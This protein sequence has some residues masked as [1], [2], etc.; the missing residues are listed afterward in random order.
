MKAALA[1]FGGAG[2]LKNMSFGGTRLS[3]KEQVSFAKRLAFLINAG[4]TL[5][6]G[7]TILREQGR[8]RTQK[9]VL[10]SVLGDI[11]AG[12]S[13]SRSFSK[14]PKTF[15]E[16]TISIVKVGE[17]SGTLAMSLTYLAE[18][19]RKKQILRRKVVSAFVYPALITVATLGIT[20]FLMLYLFPKIMPVF[21]SL[22]TELPLTTR[23][24]MATSVFFQQWGML[25]LFGTIAL[26]VVLLVTIKKSSWIHERVDRAILRLPVIGAIVQYY[27]VANSTRT[28]GLL[29]KSGV[30]LGEAIVITA[31]TTKNFVYKRHYEALAG[32]V[33]RGERM[34]A[35]LNRHRSVFPDVT[36]HMIAVGERSGTLSETLVY[37]SEL[38][39][40]EVDEF[41]KNLSTLIEPALMIV[42][43]VVVGFIAISIITPIYGI[44]QNLHG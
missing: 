9:K 19:L 18:E 37:L 30:R 33:N 25:A 6:E 16:F 14:F 11:T 23:M 26:I 20:A 28:L 13:L 1:R 38:Y 31:D 21:T 10:D 43:G 3:L 29:L 40:H 22:H 36:A 41:T 39:E 27:N 5:V 15:G 34:S 42:M 35:Y 4:I 17:S 32:V 7:L 8:G 44:T 12:Q 24:V 2:S